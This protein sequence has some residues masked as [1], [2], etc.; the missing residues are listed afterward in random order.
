MMRCLCAM[1]LLF[2]AASARADVR[3]YVKAPDD[4]FRW[5]LE[6]KS[7]VGDTTI[8]ELSMTSQTWQKILWTHV[9]QIY[10]AKGVEPTKTAFIYNTGGTPNL[11]NT[12]LGT[13]LA[14]R[15]K[16]PV[17]VVYGIPNQPLLGDLKE[18]GLIAQTFVEYLKTKDETWPLL[19]PMAKSVVR[20]MDAV[21]AFAREEW[22]FGIE[23]FVVSGGSKRGWTAWM[24]AVADERVKAII[25]IVIDTLNFRKQSD[26][27]TM[28]YGGPSI[29]VQDY[30]S[31]GLIRA[32]DTPETARLW[33]IV[34][35]WTYRNELKLPKLL[36]NGSNDPYWTVDSLNIYW[37][38]LKG[39]KWIS[40]VP[41]AGHNLQQKLEDGKTSMERAV[42]AISAFGRSMIF[43][44]PFPTMT[45]KH[46]TDTNKM[47]LV[48]TAKGAKAVRLWIADA[49]KRDFRGSKWTS[50]EVAGKD[51]TFA[52]SV[53]KPAKGFR[54][55]FAEVEFDVDGI[56]L[57]LSTQV[58]V[59]DK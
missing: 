26:L 4:S 5:K 29:Q 18:D 1:V 27:Q 39:D 50:R 42:N 3:A 10:V 6:K 31:R 32:E 47:T 12:V 13:Q 22:K 38:D 40:Y 43:D 36:L 9:V 48:V 21:Q 23:S 35:P 19:F 7:V 17:I 37:D 51:G 28:S 20:A 24:T 2:S 34:D 16:A 41:N 45:W 59:S 33:A 14:A 57:T 58:R 55:F 8:Y 30:T 53:E 46:D 49:D 25:P 11:T 52:D 15:M 44:K 56:P 54:S